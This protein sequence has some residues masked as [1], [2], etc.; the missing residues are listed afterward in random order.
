AVTVGGEHHGPR[1][2]AEREIEDAAEVSDQAAHGP[3]LSTGG[4]L[5]DPAEGPDD[6]R[7]AVEQDPRAAEGSRIG[8]RRE[9]RAAIDGDRERL[10]TR[11]GSPGELG[12]EAREAGRAVVARLRRDGAPA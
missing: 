1:G 8:D 3:G 9:A 6:H 4:R 12:V 2:V 11:V 5:V 10:A 7:G